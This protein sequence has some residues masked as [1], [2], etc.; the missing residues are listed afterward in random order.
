MKKYLLPI[1]S[2]ISFLTVVNFGFT[3][4]VPEVPSGFFGCNPR[5]DSFSECVIKIATIIFR[6]L[7]TLALIF[8][9]VMIIWGG[10]EYMTSGQDEQKRAKVKDRII[11]AAIGLIVAFLSWSLSTFLSARISTVATSTEPDTF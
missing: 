11:Y 5:I 9:T 6:F 8:A 3:Q 4:E 1:L 2:L 10:F 7:L